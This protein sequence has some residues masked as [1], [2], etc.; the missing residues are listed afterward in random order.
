MIK[1]N[2]ATYIIIFLLLFNLG[3]LTSNR[4]VFAQEANLIVTN[5]TIQLAQKANENQKANLEVVEQL[6]L[7]NMATETFKDVLQFGIGGTARK[8]EV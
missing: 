5:H 7:K 2:I 6:K 4:R 3:T 1:S 8:A